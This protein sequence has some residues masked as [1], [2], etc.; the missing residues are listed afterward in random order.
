MQSLPYEIRINKTNHCIQ[1]TPVTKFK[2]SDVCGQAEKA[3]LRHWNSVL[4]PYNRPES[5][6]SSAG[7]IL[8]TPL[9]PLP[10][11]KKPTVESAIVVVRIDIAFC[12][13][14]RIVTKMAS[15]PAQMQNKI[16]LATW[17]NSLVTKEVGC[18]RTILDYNEFNLVWFYFFCSY[19]K[20]S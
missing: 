11:Q 12:F 17:L 2:W 5:V 3:C 6:D 18:M 9:P 14:L 4:L 8:K 15:L 10:P 13:A 20:Y 19:I 16:I 1:P 7:K